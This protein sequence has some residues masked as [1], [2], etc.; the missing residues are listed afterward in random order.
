MQQQGPPHQQM[1]QQQGQGQSPQGHTAGSSS[2]YGAGPGSGPSQLPVQSQHLQS[3]LQDQSNSAHHSYSPSIQSPR[4]ASSVDRQT[5]G[6]R[7][8]SAAIQPSASKSDS[9]S[10]V[11]SAGVNLVSRC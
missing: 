3:I 8:P 1:H 4:S 6:A 7:P 2:H 9:S 5:P 10:A 11:N